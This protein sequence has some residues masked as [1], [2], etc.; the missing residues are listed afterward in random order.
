MIDLLNHR[1]HGENGRNL[2]AF[3]V[4]WLRGLCVKL[5][6]FPHLTRKLMNIPG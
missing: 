6:A 5:F 2:S 4:P 3:S 1:V